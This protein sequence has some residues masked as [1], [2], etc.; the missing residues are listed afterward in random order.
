[1][2]RDI[3]IR[4]VL[5]CPLCEAERITKWYYEDDICWIAD[6]V[7]CGVPMVVWKNHGRHPNQ[8]EMRHMIRKLIDHGGAGRVD[9]S[10]RQIADHWHAHL[11]P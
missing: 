2:S 6:C 4:K 3:P 11:R 7:V 10:M 1:M 5:D 9:A 8:L